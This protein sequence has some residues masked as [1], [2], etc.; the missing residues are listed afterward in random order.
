LSGR[1]QPDSVV[2]SVLAYHATYENAQLSPTFFNL[3]QS[4]QWLLHQQLQQLLQLP[5]VATTTT[6]SSA[7]T[8]AA[9]NASATKTTSRPSASC[10]TTPAPSLP[11][12]H[13]AALLARKHLLSYMAKYSSSPAL[14]AVQSASPLTPPASKP[15]SPSVPLACQLALS[16]PTLP[17]QLPGL[18]LSS[19]PVTPV[20]PP[21]TGLKD[22][23]PAP[24]VSQPSLPMALMASQPASHTVA[25][26][27]S[28]A[29]QAAP[30]SSSR[31]D[32]QAAITSMASIVDLLAVKY[33]P[34]R[35]MPDPFP[36]VSWGTLARP[37]WK[38]RVGLPKANTLPLRGCSE[39]P[40][41]YLTN[42]FS[43]CSPFGHLPGYLTTMGPVSM[44]KISI[45]GYSFREETNSWVISAFPG[46]TRT[47][48]CRGGRRTRPW[49]K[50]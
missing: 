20:T 44:P 32:Q 14:S 48:G 41:D 39:D 7:T 15:A 13:Q 2:Q 36:V 31:E 33:A 3:L 8:T 34:F 23:P 22:G 38:D 35:N 40:N 47:R 21:A 27:T 45:N 16:L 30:C 50:R 10:S 42:F 46:G 26:A 6:T 18:S 9:T 25:P 5:T 19:L 37:N 12:S 29:C 17:V 43:S 24:Q 1:Q 11:A 4:T 28:S 49:S